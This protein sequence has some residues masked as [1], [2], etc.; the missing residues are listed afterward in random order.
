[1][2]KIAKDIDKRLLNVKIITMCI[3]IIECIFVFIP[4]NYGK[5][6][7]QTLF[8]L[9]MNFSNDYFWKSFLEDRAKT[10]YLFSFISLSVCIIS[11]VIAFFIKNRKIYRAMAISAFLL[12]SSIFAFICGAL[13]DIMGIKNIFYNYNFISLILSISVVTFSIRIKLDCPKKKVL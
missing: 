2:K 6:N 13:I 8:N 5:T 12:S 4:M 11:F 10:L 3:L 1:M 9:C 7:N